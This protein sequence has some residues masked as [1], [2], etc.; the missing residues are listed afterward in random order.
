LP[1]PAAYAGRPPTDRPPRRRSRHGHAYHP[2]AA[3]PRICI[4]NNCIGNNFSLL[5]THLLLAVLAQRFAP[6]LREGWAPRWE[7][8]GVLG[9]A[10]GLPM[11]V[12]RR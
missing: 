3:G 8:Q 9:L 11:V 4:G 10:G 2:F 1:P 12:A 6:R 5:E 7:M